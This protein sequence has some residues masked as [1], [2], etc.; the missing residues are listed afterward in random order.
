MKYLSELS[1]PILVCALLFPL[2]ECIGAFTR[3]DFGSSDG[4]RKPRLRAKGESR[5]LGE[6]GDYGKRDLPSENIFASERRSTGD[7]RNAFPDRMSH[8]NSANKANK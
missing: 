8:H 3:A 6:E 1:T 5:R 2:S 7:A 4:E